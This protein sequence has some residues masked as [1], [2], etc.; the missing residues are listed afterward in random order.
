MAVLTTY[1]VVLI[2]L[3]GSGFPFRILKMLNNSRVTCP[4]TSLSPIN[5]HKFTSYG[6]RLGPGHEFI[7]W[8]W[9][10]HYHCLLKLFYLWCAHV[11]IILL[12]RS[13]DNLHE[14]VLF[15]HSGFWGPNSDPHT[16]LA[17]A[18]THRAVLLAPLSFLKTTVNSCLC[19]L[20]C[21]PQATQVTLSHATE[22]GW[23][24]GGAH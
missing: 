8:I 15:L 13:E 5:W 21:Y 17:G 11:R 18:I 7:G 2:Y 16:C 19:G 24:H 10:D 23:V 6:G 1:S 3:W 20:D 4:A 22:V 9:A 14:L 12:W